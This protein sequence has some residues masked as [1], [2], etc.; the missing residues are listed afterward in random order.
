MSN[1]N[2]VKVGKFEVCIDGTTGWFE[3]YIYGEELGGGL[4]FEGKEL[5][6][7]DGVYSLPDEVIKAIEMLGYDASN[8]K[9]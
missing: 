8:M 4:W 5:V 6:D 2:R 9:E 3:H 7:Y 1:E